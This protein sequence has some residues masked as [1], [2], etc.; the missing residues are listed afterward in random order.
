MMKIERPEIPQWLDENW[1]KWGKQ[2]KAKRE[3]PKKKNDWQWYK[4]QGR[5]INELLAPLLIAMTKHHCSFC[6]KRP[7]GVET[8]DHFKPKTQFPLES[9]KWENLFIACYDCQ[10]SRWETYEDVLLKPDEI[11][12]EFNRYFIYDFD[13]G[14]LKPRGEKD[15]VE[16]LRADFTIKTFKLN[17][18]GL[19]EARKI[20]SDNISIF[21]N[22]NIDKLPYRFILQEFE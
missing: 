7:I 15:S 1:E 14:E 17:E 8:I 21:Q 2:W 22:Q 11:D 9:Y 3:N 13:L 18:R 12:Y 20:I 16:Y 6:D 10:V 4:Y 5:K 19:P